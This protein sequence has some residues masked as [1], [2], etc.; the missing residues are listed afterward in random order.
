[1]TKMKWNEAQ[2]P[3]EL[4][5]HIDSGPHKV[6]AECRLNQTSVLSSRLVFPNPNLPVPNSSAQCSCLIL[7]ERPEVHQGHLRGTNSVLLLIYV[8]TR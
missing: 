1:M 3:E 2:P 7:K 6:G 5:T 8:D 4:L